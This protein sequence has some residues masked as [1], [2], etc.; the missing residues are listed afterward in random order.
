[1]PQNPKTEYGI[2][3][4]VEDGGCGKLSREEFIQCIEKIAFTAEDIFKDFSYEE[5]KANNYFVGWMEGFA[6]IIHKGHIT[7]NIYTT[8]AI[9]L[10]NSLSYQIVIMDPKIQIFGE[11]PQTFP[12]TRISLM[13]EYVGALQIYLKVCT[14]I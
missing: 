14:C 8:M 4:K 13:N 7:N 3:W 1:M 12:N 9:S 11:I 10:N 5:L 6:Q 2:G